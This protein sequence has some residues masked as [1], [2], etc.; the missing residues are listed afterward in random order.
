L[1]IACLT[2]RVELWRLKALTEGLTMRFRK[3]I[4]SVALATAVL[5]GAALVSFAPDANASVFNITGTFG[6]VDLTA[7][8]TTSDVLLPAGGY[9]IT[10]ITGSLTGGYGTITGL[11][12]NSNVANTG[13]NP[14]NGFGG[15]NWSALTNVGFGGTNIGYDDILFKS[16]DPHLDNWGVV[17][18]LS[19]G[20]SANL[21]GN[22]PGVYE[23]FIGVPVFDRVGTLTGSE[24][25]IPAAFP[26]FASG[27]GV[28]GF[29]AR[30]RKR[31]TAAALAAA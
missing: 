30:R 17:F 19:D 18:T 4:S 22:S 9:E 21:F 27:L 15:P 3:L 8:V 24:T 5:G 1:W 23:L 12:S 13:P 2:V 6:T 29:L 20:L 10:G 26:L 7:T 31:K 16:T 11:I 28:M 25:P 14:T